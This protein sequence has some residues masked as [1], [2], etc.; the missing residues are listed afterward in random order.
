MAPE[1]PA[2]GPAAREPAVSRLARLVRRES[3]TVAVLVVLAAA[4]VY[5]AASPGHWLRGSGIVALSCLLAGVLRLVLPQ[6]RAGA[7]VVRRRWWDVTCYLGL[8][9]TILVVGVLLPS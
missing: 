8:G 9:V 6:R 2:R 5:V 1:P 7:L 4:P 3:P